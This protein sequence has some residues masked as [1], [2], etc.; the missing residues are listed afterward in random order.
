MVEVPTLVSFDMVLNYPNYTNKRDEVL[1]GTG[2]AVVPQGTKVTWQLKTKA[3]DQVDLIAR[4]TIAVSSN[5]SVVLKR[6]KAFTQTLII[7]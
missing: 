1:K 2:N 5:K 6:L 7:I 3:T 4:D